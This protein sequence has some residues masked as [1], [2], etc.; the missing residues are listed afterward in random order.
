M[1]QGQLDKDKHVNS[2]CS[3]SMAEPQTRGLYVGLTRKIESNGLSE[4]Q[5]LLLI[6]SWTW[7]QRLTRPAACPRRRKCWLAVGELRNLRPQSIINSPL[8]R[9]SLQQSRNWSYLAC[10]PLL[11]CVSRSS[12]DCLLKSKLIKYRELLRP[13]C[14][15]PGVAFFHFWGARLCVRLARRRHDLH[16]TMHCKGD[17]GRLLPSIPANPSPNY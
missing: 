11:L 6:V 13:P 10:G 17:K 14:V 12:R 3:V 1:G 15:G 4:F 16:I 9:F 5:E 8:R 2:C 7:A